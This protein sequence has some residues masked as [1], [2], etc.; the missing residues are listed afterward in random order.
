M[1]NIGN[2]LKTRRLERGLN[3]KGVADVAGVTNAAVSK[4]E[5]NGGKSMSAIVAMRLA[6]HLRVNPYWLVLGEGAP[7]DEIHVPDISARSQDVARRIDR[8]PAAVGEAIHGLL[9]A[10][11]PES[12]NGGH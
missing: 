2:R 7:T 8:L 6:R 9:K 10:L 4:W 11:D 1:D 5:T 3:Q 12:R